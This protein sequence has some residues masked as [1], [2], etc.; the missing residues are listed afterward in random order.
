MTGTASSTVQLDFAAYTLTHGLLGGG[1]PCLTHSNWLKITSIAKIFTVLQSE[2]TNQIC[3]KK[4]W[5]GNKQKVRILASEKDFVIL[6]DITRIFGF[7][8]E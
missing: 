8:V 6:V 4:K 5:G 3:F 2:Y 1:S 7:R